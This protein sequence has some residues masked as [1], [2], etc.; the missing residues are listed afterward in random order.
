MQILVVD[1]ERVQRQSLQNG[2]RTEGYTVI[3]A[4][5]GTEALELLKADPD[6]FDLVIT[7]HRMPAMTGLELL[8]AMRSRSLTVPVIMMTA[9]GDK[10]LLIQ[11]LQQQ[12]NGFIDKPF[13]L[14]ALLGEIAR[15]R[16][17]QLH[18]KHSDESDES[19]DALRKIAHQ[20]NN[21][22]MSIQG[23]AQLALL[24][25]SDSEAVTRKLNDI[26]EATH[27]ISAIN[28]KVT[29]ADNVFQD[30]NQETLDIRQLLNDCLKM[31]DGLIRL[32]G[33]H[34]EIE[35]ETPPLYVTGNSYDLQQVFKN[36]ILNAI[37]AMDSS[38]RPRLQILLDHGPHGN[39]AI[40][41]IAD[42]GCGM[43]VTAGQEM[44]EEGKTTK[45][46]GS[47]LGIGIVQEAL[48]RHGGHLRMS[49]R[50]GQGTVM[51]VRLPLAKPPGT[52]LVP[53]WYRFPQGSNQW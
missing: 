30:N 33:I 17:Q 53:G 10:P 29:R 13:T 48:K 46:Q 37:E 44:F 21:P 36:L 1:D 47:G 51:T 9:Y 50:M 31:F 12:C 32:K 22:L 26:M 20:I 24:N 49:S 38:S 15:V 43:A 5:D 23:H 18:L 34:V 42:S 14:E 45:P 35:P 4:Q 16:E 3:T 19:G 40:I 2:L 7:D 41:Q 39:E 11:A 6:G 28:R 52:R 25:P 27:H 8:Q